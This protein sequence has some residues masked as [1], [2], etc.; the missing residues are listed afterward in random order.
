MPTEWKSRLKY[1]ANIF[2]ISNFRL[3]SHRHFNGRR[4]WEQTSLLS[5]P[6]FMLNRQG[7][8]CERETVWSEK[9]R[10]KREYQFDFE[11]FYWLQIWVWG[12]KCFF[13]FQKILFLYLKWIIRQVNVFSMKFHIPT[14]NTQGYRLYLYSTAAHSAW[15]LVVKNEN[16]LRNYPGN[17]FRV[18]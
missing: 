3:M 1:D 15:M 16:R 8:E 12:S 14:P 10:E 2:L 18:L 9:S 13:V 4:N 6:E 17:M 5:S 7:D 11:G